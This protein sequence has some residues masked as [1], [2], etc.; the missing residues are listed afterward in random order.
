MVM[1]EIKDNPH[2]FARTEDGDCYAW[3]RQLGCYSPIVHLQQTDGLVSAHRHFTPENNAWGKIYGK[4]VLMA[5]RQSY[6]KP[7]ESG[8]PERC[9]QIPDT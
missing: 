9:T 6:D 3:L 5:L 7:E 2:M 8:M 4:D 1:R